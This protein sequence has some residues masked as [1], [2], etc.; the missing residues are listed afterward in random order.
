MHCLWFVRTH[1]TVPLSLHLC[2]FIGAHGNVKAKKLVKGGTLF[3]TVKKAQGS[4]L[5]RLTMKGLKLKNVEGGMF[6][7]S[8]PFFEVSRKVNTPGGLTWD[9]VARSE[10]VKDNLNPTWKCHTIELSKLCG[11]DL[12]AAIRINVYDYESK[13]NHTPMGAFET[14]VNGLLRA[15]SSGSP[16]TL[17]QKNKD[18]GAIVVMSASAEGIQQQ[19][20]ASSIASD[21][22]TA[23]RA[24]V[25]AASAP[26]GSVAPM[27]AAAGGAAVFAAS[28]P[29]G[30]V[31]P[32]TTPGSVDFVDYVSGGCQ[33]NVTIGIDFTGSNGDP[34][35]PGTLHYHN[36]NDPSFRNDYEKAIAAIVSI[37]AKFDS[38]QMFP[39]YGYG[40][41]YGGEVRHCFQCGPTEEVHGVQGVLDA[42]RSVF[43]SGLIMSGPTDITELLQTAAA[44]A[45]SAQE[46]AASR[47][48]QAYT[49]LL[50]L[51]DGA[52]SDIQKTANVLSQISNTPMSVVIVGVGN[53]DFAG[54]R[55]LDDA[56][57]GQKDIT[58]FVQ[59][60][61]HSRDSVALTSET[62]HEIPNQLVG[63]FQ[64]H[65]IPPLPPVQRNDEDIVIEPEEAEIDLNLDLGSGGADDEIVVKSGGD[66]FVSGFAASR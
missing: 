27:R 16:F 58:Q 59:F 57:M 34:R 66:D 14:T 23:A 12:D 56:S 21:P 20:S 7:K 22:P 40:A 46:E 55:F 1:S 62:L 30:S 49:I 37:L 43:S 32:M 39:V 53:A 51:T 38:D 60:N 9:N 4:G 17:I 28:A 47:G 8:D 10:V 33:L 29:P 11:G 24:N 42:Y 25:F 63:Y 19:Q 36:R 6:A 5:L 35:I 15:S 54:M 48:Q 18:V 52:V 64:R 41:K 3:A 65:S 13:G 31:R 45:Q 2:R 44:R 61:R 26:P 50:V